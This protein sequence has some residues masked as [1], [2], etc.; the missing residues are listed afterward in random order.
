M[1]AGL[2]H[3]P[4]NGQYGDAQEPRAR[5]NDNKFEPCTSIQNSTCPPS[6]VHQNLYWQ[7]LDNHEQP[8]WD[9]Y[10]IIQISKYRNEIR[11]QIYRADCVRYYHDS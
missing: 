10:E 3:V 5:Y 8:Q 4:P 1:F 7:Q 6:R 11:D 9:D 2:S